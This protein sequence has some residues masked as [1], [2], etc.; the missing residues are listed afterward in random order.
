MGENGRAGAVDA[1]A[2]GELW[3]Y[4]EVFLDVVFG[5]LDTVGILAIEGVGSAQD[6]EGPYSKTVA[7][8]FY[9]GRFAEQDL[10]CAVL[11]C[12]AHAQRVGVAAGRS[13]G[14]QAVGVDERNLNVTVAIGLVKEIFTRNVT[15][16]IA[17]LVDG[18]DD[19]CGLYDHL[20]TLLDGHAGGVVRVF[21][22]QLRQVVRIVQLGLVVV[23]FAVPAFDIADQTGAFGIALQDRQ[24]EAERA[25]LGL[26]TDG[27]RP[28]HVR[29]GR[30]KFGHRSQLAVVLAFVAC[31]IAI[32]MLHTVL[33]KPLRLP[34][35]CLRRWQCPSWPSIV[36]L[37]TYDM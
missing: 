20:G 37:C 11:R 34:F 18:I 22:I 25:A 27:Q 7:V 21:F 29:S 8:A 10:R 2:D 23:G 14:E 13:R 28:G 26:R 4:A 35:R 33:L 31:E 19:G 9:R 17:C 6:A 16:H 5:P 15:E 24:D 36:L 30:L 12:A 3:I 32:H 1:A